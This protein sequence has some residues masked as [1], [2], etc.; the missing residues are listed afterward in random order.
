[1]KEKKDGKNRI[2]YTNVHHLDFSCSPLASS[3]TEKDDLNLRSY[4][5]HHHH[6]QQ[7]Q[8]QHHHHHHHG[9][10]QPSPMSVTFPTPSSFQN[11]YDYISSSAADMYETATDYPSKHSNYYSSGNNYKTDYNTLLNLTSYENYCFS[12]EHSTMH[13]QQTGPMLPPFV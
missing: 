13:H 3:T 6:H 1:M 8:Q 7:Q 5:H 12:S 10:Y 4:H 9:Y 11:Q 2:S